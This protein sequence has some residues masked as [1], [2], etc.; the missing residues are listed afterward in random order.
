MKKR[1]LIYGDRALN[2]LRTDDSFI[3][4]SKRPG[5]GLENNQGIL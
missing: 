3:Q 1:I 4:G 5:G 2:R